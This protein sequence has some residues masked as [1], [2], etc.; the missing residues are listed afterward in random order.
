MCIEEMLNCTIPNGYVY[1]GGER[2]RVEVELD[3]AL[4]KNVIDGVGA[5]RGMLAD[6]IT[7]YVRESAKCREC[8]MIDVCFT[9]IVRKPL[10]KYLD[11]LLRE[12]RGD[13]E[14]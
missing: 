6:N 8:S 4:R 12:A 2:R 14:V 7:P 11:K 13:D 9:S 5:L 3:D 1:Y 10:T